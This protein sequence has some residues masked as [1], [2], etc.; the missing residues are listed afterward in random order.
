M[1]ISI[2]AVYAFVYQQNTANISQIIQNILWLNGWDKRVEITINHNDIAQDLYDFPILIFLSNSSGRNK[3]NVSFVFDE[4][5][6]DANRK[7]IAVTTSDGATQCYAEIEKWGTSN[8]K[9]WLWVKVPSISSTVDTILYLYY[10]KDHADNTNFIGDTGSTAAQNVW[11]SNFKGVWHLG[12]ASGGAGA[13]KDST[14][15]NNVGTSY[16]SPIFGT[17]G[18]IDS[19]IVFDGVDDYISIPNSASLQFTTSL[20]IEGWVKLDS[21]GTGSDVDIVL[22]KGEGNP[23]DYQLAINDQLLALTIE[24]ND[25]QGLNSFTSFSAN[26]WYYVA[27]TWNGSTRKVFVNGSEDRSGSK[28]GNIIPDTRA[29]YIG[30]RSGTD[31]SDGIV[32]EVRA[33]NTNRSAA[34]IKASYETERDDLVIFGPE[35][36]RFWSE[37]YKYR[38][39]ITITNNIAS[40]LSS[41]YSVLLTMDTLSL[42]SSGKMLSNGSDLRIVYWSGD[43]WVELDR[44]VINVNS[45]STQI[46][47]N[48]QAAIPANGSDNNYYIYYGNPNAGNPPADWAKIYAVGDNFNGGTITSGLNTTINGNASFTENGGEVF[49]DLGTSDVDAGMMVTSNPLPSNK[50]F[51]VRLKIKLISLGGVSP[52]LKSFSINQWNGRPTVTTNTLYNP[53]RRIHV[54]QYDTYLRLVYE[55]V[56]GRRYW[57]GTSWTSTSFNLPCSLDTY[58]IWEF[59]SNGANWRI[60]WRNANETIIQQTGTVPWSSVTD[61]GYNW[62]FLW[63]EPYTN[64]Y[65]GDMRADF[66]L[67]RNYVN[68]E[69]TL[70]S[71]VEEVI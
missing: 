28:T 22:R 17:S 25:G 23:N 50:Q 61:N 33:S 45:I 30:G 29:I 44:D 37:D 58:Y 14:T 70:T 60:I 65:W 9:S 62:W 57:N 51:M 15:N 47:F 8:R 69:P 46:W 38:R 27:G 20:T 2:P 24:E 56:A 18:Q 7:K 48:T 11:N 53:T 41:N 5:Q 43:S 40:T 35:K 21:F 31:L 59:I 54:L 13:I 10:D 34:W 64:Y 32:D 16:G 6:N 12:E 19:A 49:M 42:V 66:F 63:G 55:G 71:D 3:Y 26:T 4:L 68:P 36:I 1:S 52:E 67:L 39:Q